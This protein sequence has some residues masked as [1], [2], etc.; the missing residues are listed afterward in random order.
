MLVEKHI[1]GI[2]AI[3]ADV[4]SQLITRKYI[5]YTKRQAI[6]KFKQEIKSLN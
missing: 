3:S 5:G 1:N 2:I 4:N 6:Q